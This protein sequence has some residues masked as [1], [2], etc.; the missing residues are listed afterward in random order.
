M[1]IV[2]KTRWKATLLTEARVGRGLKASAAEIGRGKCE[3]QRV[4]SDKTGRERAERTDVSSWNLMTTSLC[5][6]TESR[7]NSVFALITFSWTERRMQVFSLENGCLFCFKATCEMSGKAPGM[8]MTAG[9]VDLRCFVR[10]FQAGD[11]TATRAKTE[12]NS[13]FK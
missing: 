13:V 4:I 3:D 9:D 7:R 6:A 5:H 11:S 10:C 2:R 12:P 8:W 1:K